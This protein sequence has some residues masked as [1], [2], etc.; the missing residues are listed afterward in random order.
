MNDYDFYDLIPGGESY[1]D[2]LDPLGLMAYRRFRRRRGLM[3]ESFTARIPTK[4]TSSQQTIG[5]GLISNF[6]WKFEIVTS[7]NEVILSR[8]DSKDGTSY[9][10]IPPNGPYNRVL[11]KD[12]SKIAALVNESVISEVLTPQQRMRRKLIMRRLAPRLARARK[13]SMKRRAGQDILMRRA[14]ALARKKVA[15]KLLGGRNKADVSFAEKSRVEKVLA[16][17]S[18]MIDR[19]A[20]KFLPLVRKKQAERFAHKAA[21]A[22]KDTA[23]NKTSDSSK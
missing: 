13:I 2:P 16:K 11:R 23:S 22:S 19:L 12:L 17:R 6:D 8:P 3:G 9:I 1:I 21:N 5:N 4:A 20:M 7:K 18:K 15:K 10:I 14:R